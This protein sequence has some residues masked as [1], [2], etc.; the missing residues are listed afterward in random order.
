MFILHYSGLIWFTGKILNGICQ[1]ALNALTNTSDMVVSPAAV[2]VLS[3][4]LF[5]L[6]MAE[7]ILEI[8]IPTERVPEEHN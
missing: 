2:L 1:G 8:Y 4:N 6:S 7:V 5:L 3:I